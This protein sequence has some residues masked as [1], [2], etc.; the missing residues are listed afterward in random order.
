MIELI[1]SFDIEYSSSLQTDILLRT[2][3]QFHNKI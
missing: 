2:K 1:L 3:T